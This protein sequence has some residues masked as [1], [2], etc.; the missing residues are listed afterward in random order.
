MQQVTC[1]MLQRTAPTMRNE[2]TLQRV[3]SV[4]CNEQFLQRVTSGFT[5]SNE[6]PMNLQRVKS[7]A[8]FKKIFKMFEA[9]SNG[10][11]AEEVAQRCSI[12]KVFLKVSQN[13]QENNCFRFSF[14]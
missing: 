14:F 11:T 13:L 12:K 2:Q 3:R 1:A 9:K 8:S 4:F 10:P 7:Y 6:Q 5:M